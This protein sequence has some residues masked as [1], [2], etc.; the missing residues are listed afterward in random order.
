[1]DARDRSVAVRTLVESTAREPAEVALR[2]ALGVIKRSRR[3]PAA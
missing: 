3:K 2:R 1:M